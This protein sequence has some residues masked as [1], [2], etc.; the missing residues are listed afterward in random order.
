MRDRAI[1][2]FE[3][4]CVI[5]MTDFFEKSGDHNP[6]MAYKVSIM[7]YRYTNK[8]YLE[9]L[10]NLRDLIRALHKSNHKDERYYTEQYELIQKAHDNFNLRMSKKVSLDLKEQFK[11]CK[12]VK[13]KRPFA[14]AKA[15][16]DKHNK[17]YSK[18]S[19]THGSRNYHLP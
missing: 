13:T 15:L 14:E 10:D 8:I 12:K 17:L 1:G 11:L 18:I 3:S 2:V 9:S 4:K 19:K 5:A 16:S 7:D 6:E